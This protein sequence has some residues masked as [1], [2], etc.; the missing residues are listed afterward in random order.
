[1]NFK[2]ATWHPIAIGLAVINAGAAAFAAAQA[3][4]WHATLHVVLAAAFWLWAQRLQQR[5]TQPQVQGGAEILDRLDALENEVGGM[6]RELSE[7]QERLDFA[8]RVLAQQ[9]GQRRLG[10]ED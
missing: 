7:A 1:M 9:P 8:E 4:P 10:T 5:R 3:E 6:R 2:P